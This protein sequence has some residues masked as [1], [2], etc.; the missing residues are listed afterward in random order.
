MLKSQPLVLQNV[1]LFGDKVF[2]DMI[3]LNEA[4]RVEY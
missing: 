2:K 3:K 1:I 4:I